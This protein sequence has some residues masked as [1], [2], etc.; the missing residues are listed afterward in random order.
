MNVHDI[1]LNMQ[2]NCLIFEFNRCSHFDA[3]KTFMLFLKNLFDLRFTLN[4]VF[5]E[6]VDLL[7]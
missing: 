2:S 3:F 1:L 4:F 7:N 6:F 5:T